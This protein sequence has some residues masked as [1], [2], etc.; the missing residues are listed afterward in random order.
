MTRALILFA[1]GARDL[2]W[3]EP[4]ERLR[5]RV[6]EQLTGAP[7]VLAFLELA[8]PDLSEAVAMLVDQ[9]CQELIVVPVFLG[10]GGHVRKDLP[11]LIEALRQLHPELSI[12]TSPAAGEDEA[13]IS[14][15]AD[16][17]TAQFCADADPRKYL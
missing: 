17:C 13:V 12:R 14:A 16:F 1:H 5:Q 6:T 3:M 8:R 11:R 7:V 4:F 10:Q 9:G 2:R 15:L